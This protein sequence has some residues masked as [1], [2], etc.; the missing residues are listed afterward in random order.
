M[1]WPARGRARLGVVAVVA[2]LGASCTP[3]APPAPPAT[4]APKFPDYP[5]PIVPPTLRPAPGVQ[6][7]H[8]LGWRRLQSGDLR[9]ATRD[10]NEAL[11]LSP[12]FYP[13]ET[14]LGFAALADRDF[15][16]AVTRFASALGKDNLYLPAWQGLAEAHLGAGNVGEAVA[17]LER[18]VALDPKRESAR[19]RLELLKFRQ[20]QALLE[21]SRR[22]RQAN[23]VDE[24]QA[25]LERA[26]A[27]SPTSALILRELASLETSRGALETAETHARQA[28]QVDPNDDEAHAALGGVLEARGRLRDAAGAFA[29]AA[30]IDPKWRDRSDELREKADLAAVPAEFRAIP[31]AT[32]VTRAEVAALI[33]T[34]LE[35]L[36]ES[37]PRRVTAVA[38]D[39]RTHWAAPWIFPVTQAGVMDISP[40]H[41]F[42]PA[43]AVRR[44]HLAQI[45]GQLLNLAAAGRS[46][47]L[48]KW[49]TARPRF[50]DLAA[51]NVFYNAAA[52]AV[53]SGAM[54]TLEGSR[55]EP[56][57]PATGPEVLAAI[58]RIEQ[59][60]AR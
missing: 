5:A 56:L 18:V 28:V 6:E 20:V 30:A 46:T 39:V 7:R 1:T 11:K 21:S 12:G 26:L 16:P 57:R 33:G 8:E 59:L 44:D 10:F 19:T 38:T 29:K 47:E 43:A 40:N 23:R 17:A 52:L 55:F 58:A 2:A 37:A 45:V 51:T 34:R 42:Q 54:A 15:K 50:A 48:A 4:V 49:K 32:Q 22:D 41:L 14:G 31:T 60:T 36:I 27:L 24:A 13:A 25:S 53:T 9:G 3:K 35:K